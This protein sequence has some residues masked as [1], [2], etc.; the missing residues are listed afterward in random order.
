MK[1]LGGGHALIRNPTGLWGYI[2]PSHN[3]CFIAGTGKKL[4]V[5]EIGRTYN[6][7]GPSYTLTGV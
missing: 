3:D 6:M 7:E 1:N 2:P 5:L 4:G